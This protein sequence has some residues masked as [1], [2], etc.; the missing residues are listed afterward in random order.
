MSFEDRM[1]NEFYV[2]CPFG[3]EKAV[4]SE[5]G[6]M[7]IRNTRPLSGGVAFFGS[8]EQAF[9]AC[10]WL[11]CAS[12]VL[13]VL[14]RFSAGNAQELYEGVRLVPWH[15][16]LTPKS[17][18]AI[19]ARGVNDELRNTQ[20]SALKVKDA[21]CDVMVEMTGERPNVEPERPDIRLEL[22]VRSNK[23]TLYLDLSGEPL[24]RRGYRTA[25]VQA[26]APMKENL[27]AG[28]LLMSG[29]GL[30]TR[31]DV[32]FD[33][34]C[35]SG[36]FVLEAA[37]IALDR[38]PGLTRDYWGFM[39]WLGHD[40]VAWEQLVDEADR[41][42]EAAL[43]AYSEGSNKSACL[44]I[45]SDYDKRAIEMARES[46]KKLGLSDIL[47]FEV[48]DIDSAHSLLAHKTG[49]QSLIPSGMIVSNPPYAHRVGHEDELPALYRK[50]EAALVGLPSDWTLHLITPDETLEQH[51]LRT[52]YQSE[53]LYNGKIETR[54]RHYRLG[55]NEARTLQ[56]QGP[57]DGAAVEVKVLEAGTEQFIARLKKVARERRKWAKREGVSCYR[58]Y[59][60][61]L[62]DYAV[63][64]D[65]YEGLQNGIDRV[66]YCI[67][68]YKAPKEIDETKALR[69]YND[70]LT[71]LPVVLGVEPEQIISKLRVQA[72]GGE[73]YGESGKGATQLVVQE[74]GHS[75]LVDLSSYLDTGLFLDHRLTRSL[76]GSLAQGK[77]FLNLF[78]YT[79][80]AT[81]YAAA[82][83]ATTT[84]TV[85]LSNTYTGW[86]L[87]N[88]SLNGFAGS[89]R[90]RFI[91][92]DVFEWLKAEI[93]TGNAYDL[94]FVDPPT[95]SNS[96]MMTK[97][98]WSVQR[99]HVELLR[100][101]MA[102]LA[103]DGR[104]IFS[105]NLRTF[106][107]DS[108]GLA[109][110]GIAAEDITASTIPHDFARNPKIHKCY[111]LSSF[112]VT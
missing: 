10:L 99:D 60:S 65:R 76:V 69:R 41:R 103:H 30:T 74:N 73:Q 40:Q 105:C 75:F 68:E 4:A 26:E 108:E 86:A 18:F 84:T 111:M 97:Q 110:A 23:A 51:L 83:G 14:Q 61:D 87:K 88:M 71:T 24:H 90:H 37:C 59:D 66:Y 63:A 46:T 85:D 53:T 42:F 62:P 31:P 56:V 47:L 81:V 91:R 95:F 33:P 98:S 21:L 15:K 16:H 39:G 96:K 35:G 93:A 3:L 5:L 49:G 57:N 82:G 8:L 38:A 104:V 20:F 1:K 22:S 101:V 12:R 54:L 72:R 7:G 50:L 44:L 77:R 52:P 55:D 94:I 79:G 107:L 29:W 13:L 36:T 2:S 100:D 28:V 27:A 11:R 19:H 64:I 89:N 45:G 32:L 70:A 109:Q 78:A 67:A 43:N 34:F 25:G 9:R 102:L 58:L 112:F 6:A 17:T 106:K 80:A 92:A 48:A